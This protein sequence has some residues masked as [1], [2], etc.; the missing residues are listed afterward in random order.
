MIASGFRTLV[1]CV[2]DFAV[3]LRIDAFGTP[4]MRHDRET[5]CREEIRRHARCRRAGTAQRA[6]PKGQSSRP[7]G[8]EGTY[9]AEG[10]RLGSREAWSDGQV[11]E[12]LDSTIDTIAR[13][14]QQLVAGGINAALTCT[15]SP[16]SARKRIFDAAA[17][18]KLI[19][20]ACSVPPKG[21]KRWT[22]TLLETAVVEL[23]IVDRAS[24]STTRRT[25]KETRSCLS[26]RS[27]GWSRRQPTP[28]S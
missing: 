20:P 25:L 13:T 12:A 11:A 23:N 10:R 27:N 8:V 1:P 21:C 24:D 5:T 17:E 18:A 19:A 22:L 28:P 26:C 3:D 7:P 9:P 2:I 16:N 15:Q 14:R 4:E 6:D